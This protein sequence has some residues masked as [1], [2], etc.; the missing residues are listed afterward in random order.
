MSWFYYSPGSA[1]LFPLQAKSEGTTDSCL[2]DWSLDPR[3]HVWGPP[4][5]PQRHRLFLR[6]EFQP[7]RFLSGVF[8]PISPKL[9]EKAANSAA[10]DLK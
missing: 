10:T 4:A 1:T 6:L 9:I 7:A 8:T 3:V 2:P 5:S